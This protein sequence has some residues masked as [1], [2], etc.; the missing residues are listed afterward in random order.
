M[1][2]LILLTLI[3]VGVFAQGQT[4]SSTIKWKV[5]DKVEYKNKEYDIVGEKSDIVPHFI[6]NI[7]GDGEVVQRAT[8]VGDIIAYTFTSNEKD[9]REFIGWDYDEQNCANFIQSNGNLIDATTQS[10][11]QIGGVE[12]VVVAVFTEQPT[13]THRYISDIHVDRGGSRSVEITP[14]YRGPS[15]GKIDGVYVTRHFTDGWYFG[16][17]ITFCDFREDFSLGKS[18][19]FEGLT[20]INLGADIPNNIIHNNRIVLTGIPNTG[21]VNGDRLVWF[22]KHRWNY[23][24]IEITATAQVAGDIIVLTMDGSIVSYQGHN[25]INFNHMMNAV[26]IIE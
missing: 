3:L 7:Q 26:H 8:E 24:M 21:I 13:L 2:K 5:D 11:S 19:S 14:R 12:Q 18:V 4:V 23:E 17:N 20:T 10:I 1:K 15:L 9:G 16:N 25:P 22:A 6:I